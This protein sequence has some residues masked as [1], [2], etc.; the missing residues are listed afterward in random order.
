M[1]LLAEVQALAIRLKQ[2]TDLPPAEHA[3]LG[4]IDRHGP[5]TVPQIAR[6]R[7]TSRQNIQILVD[8][9]EKEGRVELH[10]NPAHKKSG[11]VSLTRHGKKC[12][13]EGQPG[14][15]DL[16]LELNSGVSEVEIGETIRVLGRIRNLLS[17]AKKAE[18]H[19]PG[20]SSKRNAA[21]SEL[22][23]PHSPVETDG[24]AE[25]FPVNLL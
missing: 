11:L 6:E 1:E 19:T 12:L 15:E 20:L 22:A 14:W 24:Q 9:L 4:I 7:S 16:L 8:R 5:V 10:Q 25:E 2:S 13:E 3:V 21:R 17:K 23:G 18:N